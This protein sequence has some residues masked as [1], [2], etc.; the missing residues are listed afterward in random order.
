[1]SMTEAA[2]LKAF[3]TRTTKRYRPSYGPDAKSTNLTATAKPAIRL[4]PN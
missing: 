4:N 3:I 1:M 2:A